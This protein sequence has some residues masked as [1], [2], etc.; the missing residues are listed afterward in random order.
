MEN[1]AIIAVIALVAAIGIVYTVKHFKGQGGCCGGGGYKPRRKKLS[2]VLY[3]KTFR[4]DGMHCEN[5]KARVEEV[6][7]DIEGADG[8]VDLKK[9]LLT[10][11][12]AK[13]VED[14]YIKAEIERVGYT[15]HK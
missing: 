12:Y 8:K 14:A 3:E 1:L 4:V 11:S 6:V 15:V 5:C 9:G 7:N 13:D 2:K 10:V